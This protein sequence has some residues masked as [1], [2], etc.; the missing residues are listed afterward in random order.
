MEAKKRPAGQVFVHCLFQFGNI[1]HVLHLVLHPRTPERQPTETRLQDGETNC[2]IAVHEAR[3]HKGGYRPHR[4]PWMRCGAANE[5]IFPKVPIPWVAAGKRM[6]HHA[7][8]LFLHR[9]PDGIQRRVV[10]GKVQGQVDPYTY[11]PRS[12]AIFLNLLDRIFNEPGVQGEQGL[13][14]VGEVPQ[15]SF[16]NR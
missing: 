9:S 6:V 13:Q 7:K 8:P 14:A 12:A 15:K 2:R 5:G 1:P 16:K 11:G 4:G 10:H 3:S